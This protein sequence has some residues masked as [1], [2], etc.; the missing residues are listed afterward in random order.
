MK[1]TVFGLGYVGCVSL[2][3]LARDGHDV[4][5]VDLQ[6]DKID[7]INA[8]RPTIVEKD[9]AAILAEGHAAG[10]VSATTSARE[11]LEGSDASILCVGT[12]NGPSGHLDLSSILHVA[13]EIGT[14]LDTTAPDHVVLIRSTVLPG[15]NAKVTK[16]LEECLAG[17]SGRSVHVVSNPEFLRESTAVHDFYHPPVTVIGTDSDDAFE[18]ARKIYGEVDAPVHRTSIG[19]AELIK[20]VNNSWHALKVSF[21]NEIGVI[22]KSLG[23]DSH[24]LMDLFCMDHKLNLSSYYLRPGFAYGGSCLPKDLQALT[25]ISHDRY[26]ETPVLDS[27]SASNERHVQRLVRMV[28]DADGKRVGILGLS[29]K[30]GTDDLRNSPIVRVAET[31]LG[32]G[33]DLSIYDHNVRISQLTGQNRA[34]VEQHIPHLSR[35]IQARLEDVIDHSEIVIL[36]NPEDEFRDL[37]APCNGKTVIDLVRIWERSDRDRSG[38]EGIAW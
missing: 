5:G 2:A 1:I 34:Y 25:T 9:L 35:L 13:S 18:K 3:C 10:R 29:F 27:V 14:H 11:G 19:S 6:Q 30:A 28:E 38:Y 7:H 33:Y 22:A 8:G 21:A 36:A 32:R 16:V 12:P 26:L 17:S 37:A 15:T 24:E 31:L 4:V 20:L 23:V